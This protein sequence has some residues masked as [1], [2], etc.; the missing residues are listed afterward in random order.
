MKNIIFVF[1][2]GLVLL[3]SCHNQD[4]EFP[5]YKYT[6]VYFAYQ[7]P[8]R[9]LIMGTDY[10]Y[11]NSMDTAH[12]CMIYATMGGVYS[13][14]ANRTL[15][16]TV[17]NSLCTNLTF[18]TATG[19]KVLPMP[20]NYYTLPSNM[21]IVIPSGSL[22]GGLKVQFTDAF[23]ADT[24]A[25]KNTYV[26]PLRIT[27]V[28]NA[29]SI[30]TGKAI[31]TN[32]SRFNAADWSVLPKDYILYAVKYKNP[33]DATYLRRGIEVGKGNGGATALDTTI[34]YHQNYVESD[35]VVSSVATKSLTQL[36]ISLK[37][38]IK[39]NIDVPYSM[40]MTFDGSGNCSITNPA[41]ASYSITGSGQY[42]KKGD[43]WG[44]QKRDVLHLS[45]KVNFGTSTHTMVDTLVMRDR[46][47][48]SEIFNPFL[49]N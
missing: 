25:M 41:S 17:D 13:N 23:F 6:T 28:A 27:K 2:V 21:Q 37:G 10:V 19:A 39:G 47:E 49:N 44:N 15:N 33:W 3:T 32:P 42:V 26:I 30:L 8:V 48:L 11:D 1:L 45:Y 40:L 34:V 22:M 46:N 31:V 12:Q 29:D 7:S 36:I 43:S 16:V 18:E 35:Q 24:L 14:T 20:S 4:V 5:D 9:T 38:K